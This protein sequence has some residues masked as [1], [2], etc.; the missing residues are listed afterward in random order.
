MGDH[1]RAHGLA[2]LLTAH[3]LD[4]QAETFVMRLAR[5]SGLDG[6]AAM[7]PATHMDG[8]VRLLRPLLG[9]R[10][11]RLLATLRERGV[12]WSEDPS[13]Q[14]PA[15]ERTRLRAAQPTLDA[16][17]LTPEM[18]GT[19]VRRLQRARAAIDS[20]VASLCAEPPVGVVHTEPEGVLT[21]DRQRL[22]RV[23]EEIA[24]RLL[25]RCIAAAGG[26]SEPVPLSSVE[27]I[28]VGLRGGEDAGSWTL[29]RA[30]I[31][32][33]GDCIRIER[34]PGRRPLPVLA[35]AGGASAIWDG[36][37]LVSVAPGFGGS[38]E[39]RALGADGVAELRRLG[40]DAKPARPLRLAAAFWQDARLVAV[41]PAGYWAEA[42]CK[43]LLSA[44][45]V[46][47]RYN[48]E[49]SGGGEPGAI[50]KPC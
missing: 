36:R 34:E 26:L 2:A 45:F 13:N 10:K 43:G 14:S 30:H 19:S 38:V 21:I 11:S 39:V 9:V 33:T 23:P 4:D 24:V 1:A 47:L 41:P 6:L 8:G 28:L 15:F 32:A 18:L 16:L 50:D 31:S 48:L 25:D 29:S 35:L 37:F 7:A 3:T 22:R 17:G 12:R 49:A 5:G 27:P 40:W 44:N 42:R 20:V 46:G